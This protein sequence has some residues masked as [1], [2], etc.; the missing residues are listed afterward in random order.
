[1]LLPNNE[2]LV[3]VTAKFPPSLKDELIRRAAAEQRSLSNLVRRAC[4]EYVR[5]RPG[6]R[7]TSTT[8]TPEPGTR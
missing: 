7:T 4:D 1:L 2:I 5:R 3:V 6:K 8:T